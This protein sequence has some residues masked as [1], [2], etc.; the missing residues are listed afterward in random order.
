MRDHHLEVGDQWCVRSRPRGV[1]KLDRAGGFLA[2]GSRFVF[3][4]TKPDG[5]PRKLL[6]VSRLQ[7]CGWLPKISLEQGLVDAYRDFLRSHA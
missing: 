7:G 4:A 1:A 5:T 6:D 2:V 3:D